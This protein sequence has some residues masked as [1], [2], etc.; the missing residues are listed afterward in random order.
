LHA[1]ARRVAVRRGVAR[2]AARAA[3][4]SP[5]YA[6][7]VLAVGNLVETLGAGA[8]PQPASAAARMLLARRHRVLR[9]L[10][11][12]LDGASAE[13]RHAIRIAAKKLRYA[14]EFF[15]PLFKRKRVRA[16]LDALAALQQVLGRANDETVAVRI[17]AEFGLETAGAVV[18]THA[19]TNAAEHAQALR[20]AWKRFERAEPYWHRD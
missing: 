6:R 18:R 13:Q 3:I 11:A 15:A 8:A 16:Y 7:L 17:C 10:A 2:R 4:A 9:R 14:A 20:R 19:A 5:R 12:G 1:L